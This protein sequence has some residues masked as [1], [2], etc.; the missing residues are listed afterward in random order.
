MAGLTGSGN[1]CGSMVRVVG[2]VIS[3][4]VTGGTCRGCSAESVGMTGTAENGRMCTGE[5]EPGIIMIEG[6]VHAACRMT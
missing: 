1:A 3:I 6:S 2:L 4:D 5:R